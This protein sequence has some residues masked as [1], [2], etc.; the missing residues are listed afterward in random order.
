MSNVDVLEPLVVDARRLCEN[1]NIN[2]Q[3]TI[4]VAEKEEL[5]CKVGLILSN[6]NTDL[7]MDRGLVLNFGLRKQGK[8]WN[9]K[10]E[11]DKSHQNICKSSGQGKDW[12]PSVT[13]ES[14]DSRE[15]SRF[16]F[17][18]HFSISSHF[19]FTFISRKERRRKKFH[20]FSR[21]KSEIWHQNS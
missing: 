5:W 20:P 8:F 14:L 4:L 12:P 10:R 9:T 19:Y 17:K 15:F 21:K 16:F 3:F 7:E 2:D 1:Q 11:I 6:L 18:F 13:C